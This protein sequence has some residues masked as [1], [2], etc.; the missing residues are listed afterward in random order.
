MHS[1]LY[2]R[3]NNYLNKNLIIQSLKYFITKLIGF[4]NIIKSVR[5]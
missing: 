2:F 3:E 4:Q 5:Y 1:F